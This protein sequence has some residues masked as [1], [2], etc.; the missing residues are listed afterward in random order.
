[1][2][3]ALKYIVIFLVVSFAVLQLFQ[4]DR[5]APPVVADRTLQAAVNVPADIS[6]ILG[7]SCND[8][9]SDQTQYPWYSYVQPI[10]WF[11]KDHIEEGKRELNFSVFN[12][13]ESKKKAKKLDE[14]CEMVQ[15][16]S[17]PIASYTWIH[18]SAVLSK[19]DV[20]AICSWTEVAKANI[21]ADQ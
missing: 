1:M 20:Q 5:A 12:T 7:R 16:G 14:I 2:R 9:H 4:I 11:L 8:C 10:G 3:K 13:Y 19:S 21:K 18:G 15:E 17:M 6:Q